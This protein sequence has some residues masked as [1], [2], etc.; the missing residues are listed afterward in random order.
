MATGGY[1]LRWVI[2]CAR[3][4][5]AEPCTNRRSLATHCACRLCSGGLVNDA[6]LRVSHVGSMRETIRRQVRRLPLQLSSFFFLANLTTS[7]YSREV[8]ITV[9]EISDNT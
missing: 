3:F 8:A 1:W 4:K 5:H 6:Y 2:R 7:P 9:D